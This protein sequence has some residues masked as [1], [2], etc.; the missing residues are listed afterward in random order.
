[1][2]L[3]KMSPDLA[4]LIKDALN[5]QAEGDKTEGDKTEG[6]SKKS[7]EKKSVLDIPGVNELDTIH[8][9]LQGEFV[10]DL[11]IKQTCFVNL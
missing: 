8:E 4:G 1:M 10:E 7:S 3:Y 2:A 9:R 11:L 6:R 5:S